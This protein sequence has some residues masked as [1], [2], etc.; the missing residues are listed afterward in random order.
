[1]DTSLALSTIMTTNV[2]TIHP[3][4]IMTKIEEIFSGYQFHHL[5]VIDSEG[6][7]VGILSKRDFDKVLHGMTLFK[8]QNVK[9]YN[10]TLL[11]SLLVKDV[12]TPQVV[13]LL[14]DE[15]IKIAAD[16]FK[17]NL[18]HAIPIVDDEKKLVGIVTTFD[19]LNFAFKEDTLPLAEKNTDS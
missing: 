19:L 8:S 6:T 5:P 10:Q 3:N 16:I 14:P 4:E 9:T 13:T 7:V 1:M 15:P 2:V 17:E 11:R 18:F 12:M